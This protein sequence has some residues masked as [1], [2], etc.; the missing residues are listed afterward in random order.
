MMEKIKYIPAKN[1]GQSILEYALIISVVV[2]ALAAMSIYVQRS[3]QANLKVI[4][5]QINAQPNN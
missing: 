5:D 3:A 1:G 2:A 4:E